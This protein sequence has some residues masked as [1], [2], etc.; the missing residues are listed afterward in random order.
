MSASDWIMEHFLELQ[1]K[2]PNMYI[3][4]KGREVIAHGKRL[5]NVLKKTKRVECTIEFVQS[6]ELFAY[7]TSFPA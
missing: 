7:Q 2:Y 4:V 5:S 1:E 6:G 3:A